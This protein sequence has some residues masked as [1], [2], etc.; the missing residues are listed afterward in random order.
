MILFKTLPHRVQAV[1]SHSLYATNTQPDPAQL[2][3]S[4]IGLIEQ[5]NGDV[6]HYMILDNTPF[7]PDTTG[8][9]RSIFGKAFNYKKNLLG[10]YPVAKPF[11]I[12]AVTNDSYYQGNQRYRYVQP[13]HELLVYELLLDR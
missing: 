6:T 12:L 5:N 3:K 10:C 11:N 7:Q 8:L 1:M 13:Q 4:R 2:Q 9:T